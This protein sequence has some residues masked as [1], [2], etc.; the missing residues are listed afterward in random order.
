ML[1]G[2]HRLVHLEKRCNEYIVQRYPINQVKLLLGMENAKV[3]H[4]PLSI[5][6]IDGIV[7]SHCKELFSSDV[8]S[9]LSET[10]PPISWI[11]DNF[12]S[13][14]LFFIAGRKGIGKS[15]FVL[16]LCSSIVNGSS[17]LGRYKVHDS[18]VLYCALEDTRIRLKERLSHYQIYRQDKFHLVFIDELP[19][20]FHGGLVMLQSWLDSHSPCKLIIIDTL[21]RFRS[22][23]GSN[24]NLY[25]EDYDTMGH[26]QSF[27]MQN[28]I[29]LLVVH[30]LNKGIHF[31]SEVDSISGT[32]GVIGSADGLHLLREK[33][34]YVTLY[35]TGRDIKEDHSA[36]K[37]NPETMQ[38]DYLGDSRVLSQSD[39]RKAI[40]Q[41][42]IDTKSPMTM[43]EISD[44]LKKNYQTTRTLVLK[45]VKDG[46]L[47][48]EDN[49]YQQAEPLI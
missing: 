24:R 37:L 32:V 18:L 41:F 1:S 30:H 3:C 36:L 19:R 35:S 29:A 16:Q 39:A 25:Q 42:I 15:W 10:V 22:N 46:L 5:R 28:Q 48:E 7:M 31:N 14:G 9:I 40:Y 11:V 4:P 44:G 47:Q 12:L 6:D 34:G 8:G 20:M 43:K 27:A 17:F 38:W 45:M 23:T 13:Q 49:K 2:N 33:D 21:A 26:L